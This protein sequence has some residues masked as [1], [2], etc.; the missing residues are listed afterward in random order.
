MRLVLPLNR[1]LL[2][3]YLLVFLLPAG[4]V[5]GSGALAR[6]LA[7]QTEEDLHHQAALLSL[8]LGSE[9]SHAGPTTS[10]SDLAPRFDGILAAA[11]EA[12]LA[13]FRVVDLDGR[14]TASSGG[15]VGEDLSTDLLV[16]AALAGRTGTERRPRGATRAA[17]NALSGPSRRADYRVFVA[18]PLRV[19]GELVG[20]IVL[21]RTPREELQTLWQMAPLLSIGLALA[22]ALTLLVAILAGYVLSRSLKNLVRASARIAAGSRIAVA[23]LEQP[24]GSHV[25]ETREL[26]LAM[27]AMSDRLQ[28]RL[29]YITEFAGNVSHEFKTPVSALR[30]TIEL[31][32][33]DEDM[34]P[35]QRTRFLD[36]AL[37]DLDRLSRLV[38]GLLRL[39]RAEEQADVEDI[40]FGELAEGLRERF[41]GLQVDG[42]FPTVRGSRSQVET[43]VGNLV[44]NAFRHG[45]DGVRVRLSGVE[46][47]DRVGVRVEDDGPGISP[48]NLPRVFD[49]FFTTGRAGGGT[50][51]GLA[52]V[53]AVAQTHGG[54]VTVESHPGATVFHLWFPR[55]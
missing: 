15:G 10:L 48:T 19:D 35:T 31:L 8:H 49:R 45:G 29:S 22:L 53:R 7:H 18:E 1:W 17:E 11:R 52:L 13:G 55:P 47:R 2:I 39:A 23:E 24:A 54:T 33:D 40:A 50:G 32:R 3:S 37:A 16:Q 26:A 44:E 14:V 9:L 21:S 51:L 12:T 5:L 20:A 25:A 4:A 38:G 46:E 30:G 28:E 43:A 34:E 36:N 42:P 27:A 6:D 41:P